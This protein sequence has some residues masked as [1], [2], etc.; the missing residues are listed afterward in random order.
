[1]G[2]VG[3]GG[4]V[5]DV[6]CGTGTLTLLAR[7]QVGLTGEVVGIDASLEMIAAARRKAAA[8]QVSVDFRQAAIEALPFPDHTFDVVLSSL[9][10]HHLPNDVKRRGLLEIQRVLRPGGRLLI[11]DMMR[12]TSRLGRW[13]LVLLFHGALRQ[14][15]EDLG[16]FLTESGFSSVEVGATRLPVVGFARGLAAKAR[17][18]DHGLQ[19]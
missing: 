8:R 16:A 3:E 9:M 17:C 7:Q 2:G 15:L 6:G 18:G 1:V 11:V 10:M 13:L 5:L 19:V 14:G 4:G 12:P